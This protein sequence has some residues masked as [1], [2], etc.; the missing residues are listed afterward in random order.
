MLDIRKLLKAGTGTTCNID[1][2][3][4]VSHG[5]QE[6]DCP[7]LSDTFQVDDNTS[8]GPHWGA[9]DNFA[10]GSDGFY[11]ETRDVTRIA[12]SNYFV[13]R[14]NTDGNHK[15]CILEI[16]KRGKLTL[17]SSFVDENQRSSC[18]N[19]NRTSWPHGDFGDAKPHSMLFAVPDSDLK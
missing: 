17:D 6:A 12:F 8:G 2:L 13:A 11:R 15:L 14:T 18:V 4:E 19:F 1:S 16:S 9:P 5:G 3:Y 10:I 7:T